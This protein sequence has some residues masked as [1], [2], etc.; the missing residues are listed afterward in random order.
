LSSILSGDSERLHS[1]HAVV[2]RSGAPSYVEDL[3]IIAN[4]NVRT[5][6]T[7]VAENAAAVSPSS[8]K[9]SVDVQNAMVQPDC[10]EVSGQKPLHK[11]LDTAALAAALPSATS[12]APGSAFAG[13]N[14]ST[15]FSKSDTG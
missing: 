8:K 10:S 11:V 13:F 12:T 9:Y 4:N 15:S 5:V 2:P 1:F 6:S 3:T 14:L 7:S